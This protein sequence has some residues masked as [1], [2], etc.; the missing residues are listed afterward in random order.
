MK[1]Q[2]QAT[3]AGIIT[4]LY[5]S[6]HSSNKRND[7]WIVDLGATH[8]ISSTLDLMSSVRRV[9]DRTQDKVTLPN[10]ITT[11][12][13]HVGSSYLSD[14]YKLENVLHVL[15]FKF[16]LMSVSKLTRDLKCAATFQP[17]LCVF[18]DLYN[19]RVKAIGKENEGLYILKGRGFRLLAAN[20]DVRNSSGE[21][22][23]LWHER[24]GHAS[25]PVI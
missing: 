18:R 10:G 6:M 25:I 4:A 7:D 11:K 21:T 23:Y 22:A 13:E 17:T 12:I 15:D 16:N 9:D 19:G 3:T 20:T 24:L 1:A 14:V 2:N 8:H 5:S